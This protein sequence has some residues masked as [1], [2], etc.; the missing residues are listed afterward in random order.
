LA[1]TQPPE[2]RV[3]CHSWG[4]KLTHI[5][6]H[7]APRLKKGQSYTYNPLWAF[8]ANFTVKIYL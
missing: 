7:L 5:H 6:P 8:V 2:Q 3:P 4:G 1:P